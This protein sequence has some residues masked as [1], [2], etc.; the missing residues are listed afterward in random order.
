MQA[1]KR[2]LQSALKRAGVYYRLKSSCLYDLYWRVA[3]RRQID[4]RNEELRFYRSFLKGLR[5]G[6]LIF[7]IGANEGTKTD[8]FLRLGARV[9]SVDPDE[10]CQSVLRGK[11]VRFRLIPKPVVIVGKALSDRSTVET[12]WIDGPGS[13]VNTLSQKWADTLKTNRDKFEH[14]HFGLEFGRCKAVETTTLD[15]LIVAYGVPLFVKIDVEGYEACVI[16]GLN[17]AV[18]FLSFEINLPEFRREGTECVQLLGRLAADGKFNYA[19]NLQRGTLGT[20]LGV[21][22]FL[23]VLEQCSEGTIEV[24]W[25][26]ALTRNVNQK[27]MESSVPTAR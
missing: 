25:R 4:A 2:H 15:D 1:L 5:K 16:R 19:A 18:P 22:E 9:V 23:S 26:T 7:D 6:D 17:H 21:E 11:F 20:W 12:M 24:F 3:D 14:A 27:D 10:A 13:A 8:L